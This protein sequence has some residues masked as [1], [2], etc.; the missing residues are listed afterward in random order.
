MSESRPESPLQI[1]F[2]DPRPERDIPLGDTLEEQESDIYVARH[3]SIVNALGAHIDGAM[4]EAG[5]SLTALSKG[6]A[7]EVALCNAISGD[8]AIRGR[9]PLI[10]EWRKTI[11]H[12][13]STPDGDAFSLIVKEARADGRLLGSN[14]ADL[15][16]D[17][18]AVREECEV[19][20][21]RCGERLNT[22]GEWWKD[23]ASMS[24]LDGAIA[25]ADEAAQLYFS[26]PVSAC[27]GG[28]ASENTGS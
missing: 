18:G 5:F 12:E 28:G 9:A 7:F 16:V 27:Y 2:I 26:S 11:Q 6:L 15:N 3:N 14:G 21:R 19:H 23:A 24:I 10:P 1:P 8:F 25:R 22:A 20:I 17:D 4:A 13:A